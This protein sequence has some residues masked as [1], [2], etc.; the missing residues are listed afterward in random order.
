MIEANE[1]KR[2]C[3]IAVLSLVSAA[4]CL[5]GIVFLF[6]IVYPEL[7]ALGE[8][9]G[10]GAG[11][12]ALVVV[13]FFYPLAIVFFVL[14]AVIDLVFGI[15]LCLRLKREEITPKLIKVV[16]YMLSLR[17]PALVCFGILFGFRLHGTFIVALVSVTLLVLLTAVQLVLTIISLRHSANGTQ[18][19]DEDWKE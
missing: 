3:A 7:S 18:S 1:K 4:V 9:E 5:L 19:A 14:S 15:K 10:A 11:V 13:I 12:G 16:S 8:S 6:L 17:I 2:D